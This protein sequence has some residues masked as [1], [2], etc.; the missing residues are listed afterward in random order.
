MP[1]THRIALIFC[2]LAEAGLGNFAAALDHLRA[3]EG[4][5]AQQ[6]VHL[7]WYWRLALEWGMVH[8]LIAV[9]DHPAALLR[10]ERLCDLA[11]QTDE[12]TWQALAWEAHARAALFCGE[13]EKAG[14]HVERALAACEGVQVPLAEW[15]VHATCAITF[16]ALG[17]NRRAGTHT[18]LGAAARKRLAESLPEGHPVRLTFERRSG[19]LCEA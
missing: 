16:T 19:S 9:G 17:D 8:V 3:A 11:G 7:D 14:G 10:A 6:S 15:R 5:M 2:G 18:R 4:E 1:V 13:A 12:R